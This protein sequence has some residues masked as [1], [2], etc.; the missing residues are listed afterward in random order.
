MASRILALTPERASDYLAFFDGPAFADNPD[1]ASCYCHFY[2]CPKQLNWKNLGAKDNRAAMAARIAVG[3]LEGYLAYAGEEVVGWLNVQP[4]HRVPHAFSRLGIAPTATD[5]PHTDVAMVLCFVVHPQHRR[6]GVA[7]SLLV[8]ALGELAARGFKMVEAYPFK[9]DDLDLS[10]HY[11]G[12]RTMFDAE[13]FRVFR[14]D[15][16]LTVVRKVLAA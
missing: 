3:E 9:G 1:W 11:H 8:G 13:G 12:P 4:R 6:Q 2:F 7:Q 16:K 14:E 5:L 10:D 15:E